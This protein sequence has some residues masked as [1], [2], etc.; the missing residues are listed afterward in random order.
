MPGRSERAKPKQT[1]S[2]DHT[3]SP[4]SPSQTPSSR[5]TRA[6]QRI[7]GSS[8]SSPEDGPG[9]ETADGPRPAKKAR[10]NGGAAGTAVGGSAT[11]PRGVANLTP[12]RLAKKRAN[13]REAQRAIRERTRTQIETL[14]RRIEELTSQQPFQEIQAAIRER[15]AALEEN[16][17][18]RKSLQAVLNII[19]PLLHNA[20][21]SGNG[22]FTRVDR[23]VG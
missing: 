8:L 4:V 1:T 14:E 16:V 22:S 12:E 21:L 15:D 9:T 20:E 5:A 11:N 7:P 17:E 3:D 10:A 6:K 13:D 2:N 18:I 19:Q 23:H